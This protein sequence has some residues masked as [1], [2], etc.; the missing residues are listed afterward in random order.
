[1]YHCG[2]K[3]VLAHIANG[4]YGAIIVDPATPL[5][6][7]DHEYVL[8]GGEFYL[9]GDGLKEPA[10]FDMA[11]AHTMAPDWVAFNGYAGQYVTRPLTADPNETS[12][13]S[14]W[15][16]PGR[17][18]T[19]TSTSSGRSSTPCTRSRSRRPGARAARRPDL[20][21]PAGGGAVFEMRIPDEGLYPFVSHSFASV[22]LGQV[23]LLKIGNPP[24]TMSH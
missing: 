15:S 21:V 20:P 19:S 2:T 17:A 1:M 5:P 6:K 3:P 23:G 13:A 14:T 24:G 11:K 12:S 7:A 9:N 16:P 8:V 18:W 10:A 4:M 22:D